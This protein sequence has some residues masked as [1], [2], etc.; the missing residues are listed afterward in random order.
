MVSIQTQMNVFELTDES[1][2]SEFT[3]KFLSL[4]MALCLPKINSKV[5][6]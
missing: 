5:V 2:S 3:L 4:R 1:Q 6:W